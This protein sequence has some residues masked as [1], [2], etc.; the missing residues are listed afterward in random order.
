MP[1][2]M[3]LSGPDYESAPLCLTFV[4]GAEEHVVFAGFGADPAEAVPARLDEGLPWPEAEPVV[5]V[6]RSGKWLIA[7]EST[8]PPR[9]TRPEV[10]R[11]LSAGGDAVALYQDI[12]EGDHEF[13]YAAD[14]DVV[15][16]VVTTEPP[17]W[18]GSN[19]EPF[20]VRGRELGLDGDRGDDDLTDWEVL[21]TLAGE[22]RPVV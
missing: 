5:R 18:H 11:R 16:G 13:A 22:V 7:I 1:G 2:L 9:G 3:W 12:G 17:D 14:G 21:L 4:H 10:L 19:P 6:A 15:C 8:I 20:A